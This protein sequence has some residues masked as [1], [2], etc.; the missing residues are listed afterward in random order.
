[1]LELPFANI[2]A[3]VVVAV[4]R[5]MS[6]LAVVAVEIGY[7]SVQLVLQ[8]MYSVASMLGLSLLIFVPHL[9]TSSTAKQIF[10]S[11]V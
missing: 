9:L 2:A 11:V 4:E 6:T 10:E 5:V 8:S 1:M 3:V 7:I